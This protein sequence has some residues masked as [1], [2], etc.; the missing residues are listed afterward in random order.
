MELLDIDS[1]YLEFLSNYNFSSVYSF[2]MW[3]PWEKQALQKM[4]GEMAL[5]VPPGTVQSTHAECLGIFNSLHNQD[6][7]GQKEHEIIL[8]GH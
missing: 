1:F 8:V 4:L 3:A 7:K 6:E 5:L 2:F